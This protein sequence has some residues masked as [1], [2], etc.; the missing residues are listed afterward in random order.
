MAR[1]RGRGGGWNWS[2][3]GGGGGGWRGGRGR[4]G[5]GGRGWNK[6]GRGR[7]RGRGRGNG[8]GGGGNQQNNKPDPKSLMK[9]LQ[10]FGTLTNAGN[11]IAREQR[12]EKKLLESRLRELNQSLGEVDLTSSLNLNDGKIAYYDSHCAVVYDKE[13]KRSNTTLRT[14][15]YKVLTS[16]YDDNG[17]ANI[18]VHYVKDPFKGKEVYPLTVP[19]SKDKFKS[20][21]T[22]GAGSDTIFDEAVFGITD[23]EPGSYRELL[24]WHGDLSSVLH[25]QAVVGPKDEARP[26]KMHKLPESVS[27]AVIAM[28]GQYDGLVD[29]TVREYQTRL[30]KKTKVAKEINVLDLDRNKLYPLEVDN[31]QH[32]AIVDGDRGAITTIMDNEGLSIEAKNDQLKN[33]KYKYK[34]SFFNSPEGI[35]EATL[36]KTSQPVTGVQILNSSLNPKNGPGKRKRAKYVRNRHI[37]KL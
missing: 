31:I 3:G 25:A 12:E 29:K 8:R 2:R 14:I 20:C 24:Q 18:A 23:F 22:A 19:I 6:G 15:T 5:G 33:F 35:P 28:R 11:M 9:E 17:D 16:R 37:Y 13:G 1:G 34:D 4:G 36:P 32:L 27:A 7:G 10:K 26:D 21:L 30:A